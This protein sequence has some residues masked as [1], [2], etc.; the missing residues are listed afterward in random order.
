MSLQQLI[1]KH[2]YNAGY[3]GVTQYLSLWGSVG[4]WA[5]SITLGIN[6]QKTPC[7]LPGTFSNLVINV[8]DRL[9]TG[10]PTAA[11]TL[12]VNGV[13]TALTCSVPAGAGGTATDAVNTV[14]IVKG[15]DVQF[16]LVSGS[17]QLNPGYDVS[18]SVEFTGSS[19]NDSQYGTPPLVL[20]LASGSNKCAGALGNGTWVDLPAG[21]GLCNTY[22]I[23]PMATGTVTGYYVKDYIT[24]LGSSVW[25]G[26]MRLNGVLQDGSGGTVDTSATMTGSTNTMEGAFSLPVVIGDHVELVCKLTGA[27]VAFG[28]HLGATVK[29]TA[30]VAGQFM[31][32]GGNNNAID[33]ANTTYAWIGSFEE[34][35]IDA[36]ASVPIGP[37][38][39]TALGNYVEVTVAPSA[40][41]QY[42]FTA[43]KSGADTAITFDI[44]DA[45]TTGTVTQTVQY[46]Q[47]DTLNLAFVP[48][49]TPNHGEV[50]WG[51]IASLAVAPP[52]PP[53]T[54][55]FPLRRLRRFMLPFNNN[56]VAFIDKL[57]FVCQAGV[58]LS[59]GPVGSPVQ[60]EDPV[61]MVRISRDGGS[62][63]TPE[64]WLPLGKMGQYARRAVWR[65]A[66]SYR[67][68]VVEVTVSDPVFATLMAV[69]GD[70]TPGIV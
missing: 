34:V 12:M 33:N 18:F 14:T 30:T 46:N 70:I 22:S 44:V 55:T 64:R 32:C 54:Q 5:T 29:H 1:T 60:G 24:P 42:T 45:A 10:T 62:T 66:G 13:A 61:I 16:R 65:A 20:S 59:A 21:T 19:A 28:A 7:I 6:S 31:W 36:R 50:H 26:Y 58:G 15:D 51:L 37:S 40:G 43:R 57:E 25:T 38:G 4:S 49:G 52:V 68:G 3:G 27:N 67:D 9:G 63:W 11:V 35:Q 56:L 53:V 48:T 8:F 2:G 41:K 17:I 47:G 23:Y 39:L 69:A